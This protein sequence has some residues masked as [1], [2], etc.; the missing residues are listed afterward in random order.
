MKVRKDRHMDMVQHGL[1]Q[2]C[3]FRRLVLLWSSADSKGSGADRVLSFENFCR[4]FQ[5][6]NGKVLDFMV[7]FDFSKY[8]QI[9]ST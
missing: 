2:Q 7:Y 9:Y 5:K 1:A 3:G 6:W 4:H 8:L